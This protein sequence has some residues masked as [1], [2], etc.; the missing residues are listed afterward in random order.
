M[1]AAYYERSE[2]PA[3]LAAIRAAP[4]DDLPR[5]VAADFVEENGDAERAEFIRVMCQPPTISRDVRAKE[6]LGRHADEWVLKAMHPKVRTRG[7][8]TDM[9]AI[10]AMFSRGFVASVWATLGVLN[11]ESCWQ[12][13]P[14]VHGGLGYSSPHCQL[15]HGTGRTAGVLGELLR[16]EPIAA[17]GVEVTDRKPRHAESLGKWH[18][19]HDG[20]PHAAAGRPDTLPVDLWETD[21]ISKPILQPPGRRAARWFDSEGAARLALGEALYRLH[22][23][24]SEVST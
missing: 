9:D 7:G 16:R 14:A 13:G 22:G 24:K 18:W 10:Y 4:G 21:S 20:N 23:P 3:F 15:C 17:A 8:T 5:L 6:L 11:G 1:I 2:W 12:C 19:V